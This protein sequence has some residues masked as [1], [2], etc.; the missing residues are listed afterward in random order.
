MSA[1]PPVDAQ[2]DH[3]AG[4]LDAEFV[5]VEYGDF[6]CPYCGAA[7]YELKKLQQALGDRLCLV[8]RNFPLTQ[9]HPHAMKAAQFA[10]AAGT[11]GKFWEMHDLLFENQ[12]ALGDSSLVQY[13]RTLQLDEALIKQAQ[14][15]HFEAAVRH[16]FRGGVRAG[17][18]GTPCLFINGV[19][20]N[21]PAES[22]ALLEFLGA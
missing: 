15:D 12:D 8:F 16:D 19:R 18:N 11:V 9:A 22:E 6:Q 7:Y 20:Y 5:V 3:V 2:V 1:L 14:G 13:A 4:S 10:Q 21:G 17:V